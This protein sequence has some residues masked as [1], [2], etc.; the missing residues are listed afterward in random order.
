MRLVYEGANADDDAFT[1]RGYVVYQRELFAVLMLVRKDGIVEM[2]DDNP[3]SSATGSATE[4]A[5][6]EALL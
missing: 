3:M 4:Q 1:F 5:E 2:L 6:L